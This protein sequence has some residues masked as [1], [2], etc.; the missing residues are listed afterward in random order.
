MH[1]R[2]GSRQPAEEFRGALDRPPPAAYLH[3]CEPAIEPGQTRRENM[4]D[5]SKMSGAELMAALDQARA[6]LAATQAKLAQANARKS[7]GTITLKVSQKGCLSL[8][9]L[10]RYPV[11]LYKSQWE[12][13]L[14]DANLKSIKQFIVDHASEL[15]V[16]GAA[17]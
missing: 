15:A 8:Y 10:G 12:A 9:G 11:T 3:D 5:L 1:K 17:D 6:E 14:T 4:A 7:N 13:L 16:K 2:W